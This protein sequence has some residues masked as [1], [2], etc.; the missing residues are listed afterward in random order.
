MNYSYKSSYIFALLVLI[1]E[2]N[3]KK[4]L[5]ISSIF[6]IIQTRAS[7]TKLQTFQTLRT[8]ESSF[9]NSFIFRI[10]M[11]YHIRFGQ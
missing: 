4:I 11:I 6:N 9:K 8:S 1:T 2:I 7:F 10:R 5:S 3:I